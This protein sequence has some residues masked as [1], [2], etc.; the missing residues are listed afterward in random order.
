M[1]KDEVRILEASPPN[2]CPLSPVA[3]HCRCDAVARCTIFVHP[4]MQVQAA[5]NHLVDAM[6][7][8][9]EATGAR[10]VLVFHSCHMDGVFTSVTRHGGP[11][12][13]ERRG[14]G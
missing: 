9:D 4:S 8:F 11:R 2:I 7:E 5:L 3:H 10:S 1:T 12:D 14:H 13:E 6:A